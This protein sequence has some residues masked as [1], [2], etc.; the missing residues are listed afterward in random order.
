VLPEHCHKTQAHPLEKFLSDDGEMLA[1]NPD[2]LPY[3][4]DS[5][6]QLYKEVLD[7]KAFNLQLKNC[8]K[9]INTDG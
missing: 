9:Y 2:L 5:I 8:F 3:L 6:K 4:V 7:L 1:Y